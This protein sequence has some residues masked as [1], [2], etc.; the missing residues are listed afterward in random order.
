MKFFHISDLHIGRQLNGYSLRGSQEEA[1]SR[2]TAYAEAVR[3]DAI[4]ICGDIYDKSAPPA[5]A[6]TMFDSFLKGLS[7]IQP[8]IPVLII[9]GNHDSPERLSYASSFLESHQIHISALP[10]STPEERLKKITLEDEW[11]RVN[12]YLF[13]FIKPGYVRHL[14]EEGRVTGYDSAFREVLKREKIDRRERNI[15]LAH[16]FFTAESSD[17]LL[18]DSESAMLTSGGLDQIDVSALFAFDYAALGHLHG[19]Q[20]VGK[21]WIRYSG[22]PF[23]YSV[24]EEHHHKAVTV[25]TLEEKGKITVDSLPLPCVPD[26]RRIRGTLAAALAAADEKKSHDFVSIT[27]TDE[28]EVFNMKDQLEE[29]YDH[30]L[31]IHI[32]NERTRRRLREDGEEVK[33]PDPCSSF[34]RFFEAVRHC[35]MTEQ[36]EKIMAQIIEEAKDGEEKR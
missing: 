21:E 11:G 22:T 26:V 17:P 1:L 29:V 15:L 36:Q 8:C 19:A 35:P 27:L 34:R 9:A 7:S 6:Y 14:F 25:V 12:F 18:C 30:I 31:E 10:P 16:Q 20:R 28:A 3:P 24:S 2:I 4:L 5:D 32:D 33:I 23:K 13:P